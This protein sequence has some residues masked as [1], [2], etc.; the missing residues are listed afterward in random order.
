MGASVARGF[1]PG[2]EFFV[3][4]V[5]W[6]VRKPFPRAFQWYQGRFLCVG[7]SR[8]AARVPVALRLDGWPMAHWKA[9]SKGFP[10]VPGVL[11]V[12]GYFSVCDRLS[13]GS[14]AGCAL[15]EWATYSSLES[16]S[17]GL[18][19]GAKGWFCGWLVLVPRSVECGFG[20][21][22]VG[23]TRARAVGLCLDAL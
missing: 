2:V 14:C 17:Q 7:I 3:G 4:G 8:S 13:L 16:S 5:Q 19:N 15:V 9:L 1:V 18:S 11:F 21:C 12:G 23:V 6:L 10:T 20:V 22:L